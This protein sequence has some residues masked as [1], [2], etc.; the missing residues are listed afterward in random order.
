MHRSQSST[1]IPQNE[2]VV[3]KIAN[4]V[5]APTSTVN[6]V[7]RDLAVDFWANPL[8]PFWVK[9]INSDVF[10]KWDVKSYSLH[11]PMLT[12]YQLDRQNCLKYSNNQN[13]KA[14]VCTF[15]FYLCILRD[16]VPQCVHHWDHTFHFLMAVQQTPAYLDQLLCA[17]RRKISCLIRYTFS[18]S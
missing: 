3:P 4:W 11:C 2:S 15:V 5:P 9:W 1:A 8:A 7:W 16:T 10:C 13:K 18:T 17:S 12:C 6:Q 14:A